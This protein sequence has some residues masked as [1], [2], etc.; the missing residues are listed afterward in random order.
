MQQV[1]GIAPGAGSLVA[2]V[3]RTPGVPLPS[4]LRAAM[5]TRL[6]ADLSTVRIHTG[7]NA[8]ASAQALN[9]EAYTTGEHI[10]YAHHHTPHNDQDL[11]AHEL[12]HALQQRNGPVPG[13]PTGDGL[14]V[15]H[16]HDTHEQA[17]IH[18]AAPTDTSTDLTPPAQ[19]V[20]VQRMKTEQTK[21]KKAQTTFPRTPGQE[22]PTEQK[23]FLNREIAQQADLRGRAERRT[24]LLQGL[25]PDRDWDTKVNEPPHPAS[26][27]PP[28]QETPG[29]RMVNLISSVTT[30]GIL[31]R[32]ELTKRG[33]AAS[34]SVD[35][36]DSDKVFFN[37][38]SLGMGSDAPNTSIEVARRSLEAAHHGSFAVALEARGERISKAKE[39]PTPE[40][41][42]KAWETEF[43]GKYGIT[44]DQKHDL[45]PA[46]RL[47]ARREA[48]N[49]EVEKIKGV[50]EERLRNTAIAVMMNNSIASTGSGVHEG[51]RVGGISPTEIKYLMIPKWLEGQVTQETLGNEGMTLI[52]APDDAS[53]FLVSYRG[54]E[55]VHE[56]KLQAPNYLEPLADL[57]KKH[58]G[59]QTHI[60][61]A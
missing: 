35:T 33:I 34:G 10:V 27:Q 54:E 17:A 26:S 39:E 49:E 9:S 38:L 32:Q 55:F 25:E 12:T 15:S 2:D 40:R 23:E 42:E 52:A 30:E 1:L 31:S 6:S 28:N 48:E 58:G 61:K 5:E 22:R 44:E 46:V 45:W 4:S 53:E 8:H 41:L 47:E 13:T 19:D 57:L 56:T 3:L 16:P 50:F 11:L 51:D 7:D 20:S 24:Q 29:K 36:E 14:T 59:I 21:R 18:A 60:F 37:A 43:L